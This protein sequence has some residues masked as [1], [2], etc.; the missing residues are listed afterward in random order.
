MVVFIVVI[1]YFLSLVFIYS[2]VASEK[3]SRLLK[4]NI[5][6]TIVNIV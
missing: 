1:F 5:V 4:I 6:V 3:Q 2:L